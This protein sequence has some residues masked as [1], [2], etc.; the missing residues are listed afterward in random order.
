METAKDRF[1]RLL[2]QAEKSRTEYVT[3]SS[4]GFSVERHLN[5]AKLDQE[6]CALAALALSGSRVELLAKRVDELE[7]SA[8]S[9]EMPREPIVVR[10]DEIDSDS[11]E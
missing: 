1:D 11:L 5:T 10:L 7:R 3:A 6:L 4:G 2:E 9:C 8:S